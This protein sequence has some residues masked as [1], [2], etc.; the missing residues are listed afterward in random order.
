MIK[1]RDIVVFGIQPW[2]IP[3]GSNCKN[4]AQEFALNNRVLYINPPLD[5]RTRRKS[6][7]KPEVMKRIE[8][9]SGAKED[10]YLISENIWNLYPKNMIES[11]NWLPSGLVFDWINIS[12][13]KKFASDIQ[14]AIDRLGFKDYILFNDSSMFLGQNILKYL[15]P[16]LYIYYMRDF[17]ILNPYWR[18]HGLKSEPLLMK[19]AHLIVN[20]SSLYAEYGK[21]FN[22][23]SY[24]VGQGCD[25]KMFEDNDSIVIPPDLAEI[26][27]VKIGYVGYLT[28]GRLDIQLIEHVA[29][30]RP[31]WKIVLVGPEDE[32]FKASSLH[33]MN[34]VVFLGSRR[35]DQLPAYIK[36]FDVAINPQVINKITHGNY[37]RK[38]DEYLVMGKPVVCS[39]T[40]TME[41]FGDSTYTANSPEQYIELIDKALHENT[42]EKQ[43]HRVNV[44]K[45]HSW[46]ANVAEISRYIELVANEKNIKF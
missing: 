35:I 15:N 8:I 7:E 32:R 5:R 3:I 19:S 44:G 25:T 10:L 11:I 9:S 4:I 36:G 46:E 31:E 16:K 42:P 14:S 17:L 26:K 6:K 40:K 37:P 2:D 12:N 18:K 38:I 43:A 23:H 45:S 34:N 1:G 41:Y 24:M 20:N 13:T 21:N 27:G 30:A 28:G 29:K 22:E 39:A 33:S